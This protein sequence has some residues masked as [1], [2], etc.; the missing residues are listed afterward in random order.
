[1]RYPRRHQVQHPVFATEVFSVEAGNPFTRIVVV[2]SLL[3][4]AMGVQQ[5]PPNTVI[6]SLAL[7]LTAFIMAPT[8]RV[9]Y[10]E[11][12]TPLINEQIEL[13]KQLEIK[14]KTVT[15]PAALKKNRGGSDEPNHDDKAKKKAKREARKKARQEARSNE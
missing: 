12:I 15:V 2:L 5:S 13:V 6:I 14:G 7:F 1:M 3:R 9:A 4:T 10:D 11:G 8:F